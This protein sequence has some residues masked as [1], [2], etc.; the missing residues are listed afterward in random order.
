M[1]EHSDLRFSIRSVK[2]YP[3]GSVGQHAN[4]F[5]PAKEHAVSAESNEKRLRRLVL[6]TFVMFVVIFK[7][8]SL[9]LQ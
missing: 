6:A 5:L 8:I 4:S 2:T 9:A 3:P 7:V 1:S